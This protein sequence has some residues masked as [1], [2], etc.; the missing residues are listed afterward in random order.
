MKK[1]VSFILVSI[2]AINL[3]AQINNHHFM[4]KAE[5]YA[6]NII[7]LTCKPDDYSANE[8]IT[9]AVIL[10]PTPIDYKLFLKNDTI[11]IGN[12]KLIGT[13]QN[14]YFKGFQFL[15]A[16]DEKIYGG[17]ERAVPL[18]RR[19]YSFSLYNQAAYAYSE[20]QE[21]LNF[22]VPFF[23]SSK[24]Y[25]LFFDNGSKGY[26]DI[27]KTNHQIFETG[28][29]SGELNVFVITGKDY[30]EI[31]TSFQK[32]TGTQPLPPKWALG[33]LMS[34]FGYSSE[35]QVKDIAKKMKEQH[36]PF[37]A[38]IFDLFWFGD[39]IKIIWA[40]SIGLIKPNGP[41]RIK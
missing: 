1:I 7:K 14:S 27:G 36:M 39:S 35:E 33:N 10:K 23:T 31:L 28:F 4:W 40:I 9:D 21:T 11:E 13:H 22:S 18:N 17:G 30:K 3:I 24:M 25:G 41:I 15:L 37:D 38:V 5:Q 16:D 34:R 32:L 8:N 19:G 12:A 26:A 20:G 6:P 29:M 2:S